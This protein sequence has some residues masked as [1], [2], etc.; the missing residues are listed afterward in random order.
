MLRWRRHHPSGRHTPD[1]AGAQRQLTVLRWVIPGLTG[2]ALV[3]NSLM[4]TA[5]PPAGDQRAAGG[6]LRSRLPML[7]LA[8]MGVAASAR[9]RWKTKS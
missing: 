2:A 6:G 5:A 7:A 3:L 1:L 4:G 9:S 8:G